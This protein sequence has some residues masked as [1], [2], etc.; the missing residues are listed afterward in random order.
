[1]LMIS[2]HVPFTKQFEH[3]EMS[4]D[5]DMGQGKPKALSHCFGFPRMYKLHREHLHISHLP[6]DRRAFLDHLNQT[7]F[8]YSAYNSARFMLW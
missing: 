1:M 5:Y 2:Q 8:A 4:A 3:E 6:L 7:L